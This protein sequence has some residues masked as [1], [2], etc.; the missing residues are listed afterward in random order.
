MDKVE[1]YMQKLLE[2]YGDFCVSW[3]WIIRLDHHR[4][5]RFVPRWLRDSR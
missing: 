5:R 4:D 2:V 1:V 3:S